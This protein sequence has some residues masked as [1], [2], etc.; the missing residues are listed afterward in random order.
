MDRTEWL[1]PDTEIPDR[2]AF[3]W[4]LRA[5]ARDLRTNPETW[6]RTD[7]PT[8][9]EVVAAYAVKDVDSFHRNWRGTPASEPPSWRLFADL[10]TAGRRAYDD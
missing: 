10:L 5:L 2:R 4:F 3:V 7:L 8:Y 1:S 6:A 9:L